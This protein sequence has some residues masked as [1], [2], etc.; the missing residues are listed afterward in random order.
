MPMERL[1]IYFAIIVVLGLA[2]VIFL[3]LKKKEEKPNDSLLM[4]QQQ[5][6]NLARVLDSKL[7]DSYKSIQSQ[8]SQSAQIIRDV[9]EKTD[10]I[11]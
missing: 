9:T 11:R 3:L 7:S 6:D 10:K 2:T 1:F 8:Y 4:L 5:L